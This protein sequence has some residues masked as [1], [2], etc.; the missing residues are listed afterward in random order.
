[1][2]CNFN[3]GIFQNQK[4]VGYHNCFGTNLYAEFSE[5]L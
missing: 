1:M 5:F 2:E 4:S 3:L